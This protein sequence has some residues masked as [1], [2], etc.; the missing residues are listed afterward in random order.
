MPPISSLYHSPYLRFENGRTAAMIWAIYSNKNIP[1]Y[2]NHDPMIQD[3][4]GY[5]VSMILKLRY[6]NFTL[7]FW[8]YKNKSSIKTS[9]NLSSASIEKMMSNDG[10]IYI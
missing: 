8:E 9:H 6:E 7:P 5:T 2:L 4:L 10:N 3:N 1:K